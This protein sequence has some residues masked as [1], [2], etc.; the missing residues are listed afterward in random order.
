[1]ILKELKTLPNVWTYMTNFL[2]CQKLLQLIFEQALDKWFQK[3][4][5][6]AKTLQIKGLQLELLITMNS[7][8]S[9]LEIKPIHLLSLQ[10]LKMAHA[11]TP[12]KIC[13]VYTSSTGAPLLEPSMTNYYDPLDASY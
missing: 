4:S 6:I 1:M 11:P 3:R 13:L 8:F 5:T 9:Q 12:S 10:W 7:Q 2:K